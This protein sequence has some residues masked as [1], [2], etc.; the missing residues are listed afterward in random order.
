[1]KEKKRILCLCITLVL[2]LGLSTLPL[3][4]AERA[5]TCSFTVTKVTGVYYKEWYG[6]PSSHT[7]ASY[8]FVIDEDESHLVSNLIANGHAHSGTLTS[9]RA[10]DQ[11]VY[12]GIPPTSLGGGRYKM[13]YT[14]S[15]ATFFGFLPCSMLA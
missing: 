9:Y 8:Y 15:T 13:G 12:V 6:T 5:N 3:Q 2:L 11:W 7:S 4:A 14:D 10:V 1:M